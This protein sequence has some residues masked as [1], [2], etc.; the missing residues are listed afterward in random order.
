MRFR[1]RA[2]VKALLILTFKTILAAAGTTMMSACAV[3]PMEPRSDILS[4]P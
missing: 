1:E 4:A 2:V 3:V